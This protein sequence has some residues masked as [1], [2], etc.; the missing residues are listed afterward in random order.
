[1]DQHR[2][3]RPATIVNRRILDDFD[4]PG[5]RVDLHFAHGAGVCERRKA[6]DLIGNPDQRP[7]QIAREVT[8][9]SSGG[10]FKKTDRTVGS[11]H[12]ETLPGKFDILLGD[13]EHHGRDPASS[14]D[15]LIGGLGH[16]P[17][18]E[19][20]RARRCRAS[21]RLHAV[22]VAGDEAD[23]FGIDPEPFA[24]DLRKA[25]F[26]T[27]ARRHR[28]EHNF[29]RTRRIDRHFGPLARPPGVQLYRIRD[30]DA[31][32]P[33][34]LTG[35][36]PASLKSSPIAEPGGAPQ[37]CR[38]VT[39]VINQTQRIAIGHSVRRHEVAPS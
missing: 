3:H 22:G 2:V 9:N 34:A 15:N 6:H 4:E 33:A 27:L 18:A 11:L 39:A 32:I 24:D 12:E 37:R 5:L 19:P 35:F 10:C 36:G 31:A 21:T 16:H 1:M 13:L 20:H 8:R 14:L 38:I 17:G 26:V 23:L 28:A 7:S 30:A 25:R 29:D